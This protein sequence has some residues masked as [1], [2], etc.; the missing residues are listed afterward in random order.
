LL[1]AIDAEEGILAH[2]RE[3]I[4]F[5]YTSCIVEAWLRQTVIDIY[6]AGGAL[7]TWQTKAGRRHEPVNAFGFVLA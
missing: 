2:A 1:V 7:E 6:G 3:P 5:V 4:D